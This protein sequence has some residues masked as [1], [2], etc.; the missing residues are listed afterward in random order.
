MPRLGCMHE[1]KLSQ[2]SRPHGTGL[3][4]GLKP[5]ERRHHLLRKPTQLFFEI[6][7]GGSPPPKSLPLT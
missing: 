5:D 7:W 6:R 1:R 2:V 4:S 3:A